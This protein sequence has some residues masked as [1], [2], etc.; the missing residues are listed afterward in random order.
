MRKQVLAQV[1]AIALV[2]ATPMMAQGGGGMGGMQMG[3]G[4]AAGGALPAGWMMRFDPVPASRPQPTM[5]DMSFTMTGGTGHFTSGNAAAIFYNPKD[6]GKGE[7]Q[8]GATFAQPKTMGHEAY[9]LFIGG[10][11]LQDSSQAYVYFVIKPSDGS[12]LIKKRESNARPVSPAPTMGASIVKDDPTDGHAT[13]VLLIHV[14]K[15][16]VHFIANGKLVKGMSKAELGMTTD[17][18]VG[19]RINHMLDVTMTGYAFKQY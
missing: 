13:N 7:F 9:G 8:V 1:A 19:V 12:Y 10:R 14:A 17:G 3:G 15:D 2:A 16:S 11:N 18:Q 5:K 4:N 6:I